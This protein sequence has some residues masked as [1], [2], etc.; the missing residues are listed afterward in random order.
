VV[1]DK[2][3]VGT[4]W[5]KN[6]LGGWNIKVYMGIDKPVTILIKDVDHLKQ[7]LKSI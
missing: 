7:I 1:V 3:S 5:F 4:I 6:I 2:K